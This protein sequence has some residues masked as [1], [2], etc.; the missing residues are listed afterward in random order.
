LHPQLRVGLLAYV[1]H[2]TS[3]SYPVVSYRRCTCT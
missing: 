1:M 2:L 3:C